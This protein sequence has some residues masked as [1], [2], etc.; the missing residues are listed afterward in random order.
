MAEFKPGMSLGE[1]SIDEIIAALEVKKP[2]R[3]EELRQE[4]R[5]LEEQLDG[6]YDEIEGLGGRV[7][8]RVKETA[9]PSAPSGGRKKGKRVSKEEYKTCILGALSKAPRKTM[10]VAEIAEAVEA[11]GGSRNSLQQGILKGLVEEGVIQN[12]DVRGE[13]R[14]A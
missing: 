4:A 8:R 1:A 14:L 11:I 2:Q 9:Q 7:T 13:Y 3:I 5:D 6:I 10:K 12:T